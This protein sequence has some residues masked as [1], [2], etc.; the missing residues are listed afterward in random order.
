MGP[1]GRVS[2]LKYGVRRLMTGVCHSFLREDFESHLAS[3]KRYND[4]ELDGHRW[5]E[6]PPA[7]I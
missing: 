5:V 3:V 6:K 2:G 1:T 4:S 7:S